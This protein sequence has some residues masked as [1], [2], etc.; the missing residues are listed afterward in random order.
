MR[1]IWELIGVG[2]A[3]IEARTFLRVSVTLHTPHVTSHATQRVERLLRVSRHA[4]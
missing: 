1:G 3:A 4:I 2:W